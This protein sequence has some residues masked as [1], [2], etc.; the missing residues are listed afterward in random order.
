MNSHHVEPHHGALTDVNIW[1]R[2]LSTD[3]NNESWKETFISNEEFIAMEFRDFKHICSMLFL[4]YGCWHNYLENASTNPETDPYNLSLYSPCLTN[5][6]FCT[7]EI[8]N[9]V[10]CVDKDQLCLFLVSTMANTT[11]NYNAIQLGN[12]LFEYPNCGT[13]I[14]HRRSAQKAEKRSDCHMTIIQ[15]LL[16]Q[17][18]DMIKDRESEKWYCILPH[19]KFARPLYLDNG[20]WRYINTFA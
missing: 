2:I 11:K 13:L 5:C 7:N 20:R 18:V 17:I 9:I 6:P 10:K 15:L 3:S 12:A 1:D 19:D 16:C 8:R 14:Y 4:N